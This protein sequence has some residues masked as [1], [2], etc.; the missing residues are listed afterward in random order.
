MAYKFQIG[1]AKLSG[2]ITQ[3][4]GTI[5]ALGLSNSDAN[6]TNVGDINCDSISVDQDS[7]GLDIDGSGANTGLF[8]IT[9]GDN[10]GSALDIT[11]GS[12]SYL[13]FVTTNSSEHMLASQNFVMDGTNFIGIGGFDSSIA[14]ADSGESINV[15]GNTRIR[16]QVGSSTVGLVSAT[17][18][19][20]TGQLSASLGLS[21]SSLTIGG[22]LVTSTA[23]ELNL[24]DGV[25]GLVQA[26][27]TKLAAIDATDAE[28]DAVADNSA[29]ASHEE[30]IANGDFIMFRD[31]GITGASKF[32]AIADVA[33]LFAGAGMTATNS[34][35]NVIG[36]DGITANA[37]DVAITAAQ[38]TITS[39]L[40]NS[41]SIGRADGNDIIDF[42]TDDAIEFYIDGTDAADLEM[43]VASGSVTIYGDLNV[44]GTTTTIDSA[45]ILVTGSISFEGSTAN[46]FET[47]LGVVDPTADRTIN[48]A[49]VGGTL[50]PFAAASTTAISA[51]PGEINL[52]DAGAGSST[53]V[54]S[55]DGIIIFDADDGG[56]ANSA[57]KVLVSD[58]TALAG[59]LTVA[60][61]EDGDNLAVG[62]NYF[63][64]LSSDATVTL[65]AS[66][67]MNAGDVIYVKAK[68]LT[69]GATI[70][71]NTQA[72]AQKVD[73]VDSVILESPFAAITLV[74]V[75]SNDFRIV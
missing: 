13:K 69:S 5:T 60:S 41:L 59:R 3:T 37:N 75:A 18:V 57:K 7:V 31:G 73:G 72:S 43:R 2:S 71:V 50:I 58:I 34:V 32:E 19:D 68:N 48:L 65:P 74:Y 40:N 25:S 27:F 56:E 61:K 44:Q 20:V 28:I 8:S 53:S 23:A 6:I 39:I 4:D 45:N 14:G 9:V 11:E 22:A 33:T 67:G 51:T 70:T 46:A 42:S 54:A 35:M 21:G 17:G 52:L 38:T 63:A 36:G 62:M 66:A 15:D 55:G 1:E 16:L 64:D 49:N 30:A 10:L 47:T 24:L 26:D 12:N 29:G